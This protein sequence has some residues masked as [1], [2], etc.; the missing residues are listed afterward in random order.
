MRFIKGEQMAQIVCISFVK[1]WITRHG[2]FSTICGYFVERYA[3]VD[4]A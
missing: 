3:Q 1:M 2:E 4:K